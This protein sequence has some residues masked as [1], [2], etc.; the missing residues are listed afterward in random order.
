MAKR[1][2]PQSTK[3]KLIRAGLGQLERAVDL[4]VKG[5]PPEDALTA[6]T[7]GLYILQGVGFMQ[8]YQRQADWQAEKAMR[9]GGSTGQV[10]RVPDPSEQEGHGHLDDNGVFV[11]AGETWVP[12]LGGTDNDDSDDR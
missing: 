8:D 4:A 1:Y 12:V 9:A 10:A 7:T 6:A 5:H 11:P 3:D 2:L